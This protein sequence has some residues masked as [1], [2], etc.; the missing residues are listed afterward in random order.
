LKSIIPSFEIGMTA[1]EVVAEIVRIHPKIEA[2]GFYVYAP[3]YNIME[4]RKI[5]LLPHLLYHDPS[6]KVVGL[7]R[8][9]ITAEKLNQI[10]ASFQNKNLVLAVLS[11]KK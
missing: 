4:S 6:K 10:I 11:K 1:V 5:P 2:L 8:H 7:K 9:E 3:H